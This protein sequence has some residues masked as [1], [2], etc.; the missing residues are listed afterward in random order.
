MHVL[1]QKL[2]TPWSW[3]LLE[4][5]PVVKPLENFP[6]FYGTWRFITAFTNYQFRICTNL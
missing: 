2:L 1:L 6:A 5:P 4:R 3:S